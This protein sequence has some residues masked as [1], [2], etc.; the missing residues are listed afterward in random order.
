M[1]KENKKQ[2]LA[3]LLK[4]LAEK[5]AIKESVPRDQHPSENKAKK[6]QLRAAWYQELAKEQ[7][8]RESWETRQ[9]YVY[10]PTIPEDIV[11]S[12]LYGVTNG[13]LD[14][15][16]DP[17]AAAL[18]DA[19]EIRKMIQIGRLDA[20]ELPML[21]Y[22]IDKLLGL[23]QDANPPDGREMLSSLAYYYRSDG[24]RLEQILQDAVKDMLEDFQAGVLT[25]EELEK[26]RVE[27]KQIISQY[28]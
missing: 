3:A 21:K 19:D 17:I 25:R 4:A 7:K 16:A 13:I 12:I 14:V 24:E 9:K 15:D 5:Q 20:A 8:S 18:I 28:F 6:K 26:F 22:R 2:A 11:R 27:V 1:D 23:N 10:P